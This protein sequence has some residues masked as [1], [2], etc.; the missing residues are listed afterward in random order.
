MTRRLLV[1][2]PRCSRRSH[3]DKKKNGF[4]LLAVIWGLGLIAMLITSFMTDA[5]LRLQSA[6]NHAGTTKATFIADGV[7]NLTA[8]KIFAAQNQTTG[9][10]GPAYDGTPNFCSF[11]GAVVAWAI[12]NEAG[13]VDINTA[14]PDLLIALLLGIGLDRNRSEYIAKS[15]IAFRSVEITGRSTRSESKLVPPKEA[16]FDTI[17]ELDQVGGIDAT[18]FRLLL[19]MVTVHS[20]SPGIDS[21]ISPPALYAALAGRSAEEVR[22]LAVR[23]FPNTI[24]HNR[25]ALS[26]VIDIEGSGQIAY[27]IYAE[28]L[29]PTGQNASKEVIFSPL[30]AYGGSSYSFLETRIGAPK[31]I[32]QLRA[33]T[34]GKQYPPSC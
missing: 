20:R 4:A 33:M 12:E 21:K 26:K 10:N 7:V 11:D 16:L 14:T 5:K 8:I 32:D 1:N 23:P 2:W 30:P 18:L 25:P 29:L 31:Y 22:A 9:Q 28:V 27:L 19:P 13:K 17:F 24:S 6:F 3:T 15:I 34:N